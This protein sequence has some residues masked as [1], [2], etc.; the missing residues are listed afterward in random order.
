MR[1]RDPIR[2][3]ALLLLALAALSTT[4]R[5][6]TLADTVVPL[7]A[8]RGADV[9]GTAVIPLVDS[10][11]RDADLPD[12]R[13]IMVQ[14]WYP[15][16]RARGS[17]A[18]YLFD[19]GLGA[20]LIRWQYYGL[21]TA[22]LA[23][24]STLHT[25]AIVDAPVAPG[26]HPLVTL[27][28]GLG[29]IRANYT[30]IAEALASH[31][32]IV[33]LVE[34][35]LAGFIVLPEGR[36]V[37]DTTSRLQEAANHRAAVTSWA[38][39]VVFALDWLQSAR[40]AGAMASVA[41]AVDWT[42]IGA[43]GHSSGGLVAVQACERDARIRACV[44]MDGGMATPTGE[45]MADFVR[46]GT[47]KPTLLLRSEP[48]YSDADFARRGMTRAQ[49]EQRGKAGHAAIDSVV[50]RA[51]AP[52]WVASVRGTGHFS[53]TD[54]PFVMPTT[55]TRFGGRIIA[56]E[57][58]LDAIDETLRAFF[59]EAW[60]TRPGALAAV[61]RSFPELTISSAPHR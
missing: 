3:H 55:I 29:V 53:F 17:I 13:P 56:P 61:T 36:V 59:D 20:E 38:R 31:G 52:F 11:R 27:S 15:A 22:T 34:S 12:G 37:Q 18:P 8:P 48:V 39:D 2:R 6:Q 60:G 42:R 50:A 45:P 4:V 57:R 51:H 16:A 30:S 33:M 43:M 28:V 58:G 7:P 26:R 24:W 44:D 40:G 10:S 25:H 21:D 49:W 41:R 23:R 54:A 1:R 5:A 14:L 47:T 9:V 35:P 19:R 32:V 46:T